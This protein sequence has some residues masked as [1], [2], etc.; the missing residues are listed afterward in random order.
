MTVKPPKNGISSLAEVLEL[1][2]PKPLASTKDATVKK[3]YAE[4]FSRH[5]ATVVANW[6]RSTFK[7]I[8]PNEAGAHQES[9]ARTA[10]GF[11]KLDVNY[12]TLELGLALGVSIKSISFRDKLGKGRYT[13]N[14]SRNDNELR[15]EATDYHQRQPY[16]VLVAV[17]FLPIDSCDDASVS[18][19]GGKVLGPS[20]FGAAVKFFR[21]RGNR[22]TP[23]ND[24]DLFERFFI[25]LYDETT[26]EVLF[27]DVM[28]RPP[29][30]GRPDPSECLTFPQFI[31]EII[32]AYDERNKP[33]FEWAN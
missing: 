20:S 5:M 1:A 24:V 6:L 29:R 16:A 23:K 10:K 27:F 31:S 28:S 26:S 4:R 19:K 13:K 21:P 11:K 2:K 3:N 8:T 7:N 30:S 18:K 15:A 25:G 12:S 9:P 32:R 22:K 33:P 14:Y 17:A